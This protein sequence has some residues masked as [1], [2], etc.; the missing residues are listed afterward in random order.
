MKATLVTLH[1][2]IVHVQTNIFECL[3]IEEY[4]MPKKIQY[5]FVRVLYAKTTYLNFSQY[6][7]LLLQGK[8][9]ECLG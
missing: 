3:L 6:Q 2:K 1:H 9:L 4:S 7:C 8:L 5:S